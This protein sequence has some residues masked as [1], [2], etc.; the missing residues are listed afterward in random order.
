MHL[1]FFGAGNIPHLDIGI[2]GLVE[3]D[4][5]FHMHITSARDFQNSVTPQTWSLAQYYAADLKERGVK[6]AIFSATPQG[7]AIANTR[8]ALLRLLHCLGTDIRW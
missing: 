6:I 1:S 5:A 4:S 2:G 7:E 3:I 8:N